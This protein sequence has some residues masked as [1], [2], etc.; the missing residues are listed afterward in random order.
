M[1]QVHIANDDYWKNIGKE[2]VFFPNDAGIFKFK[3]AN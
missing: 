1:A 3:N 2:F